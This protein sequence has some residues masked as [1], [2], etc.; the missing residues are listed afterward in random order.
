MRVAESVI[1]CPPEESYKIPI[2]LD[3]VSQKERRLSQF[4]IFIV[5]PAIETTKYPSAEAEPNKNHSH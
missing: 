5:V 3:V 1:L 2:V 4:N